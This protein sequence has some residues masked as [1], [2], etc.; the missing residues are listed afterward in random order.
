MR[1]SSSGMGFW[2]WAPEVRE[3]KTLKVSVFSQDD[4]CEDEIFF[5]KLQNSKFGIWTAVTEK[6]LTPDT[7]YRYEV[8]QNGQQLDHGLL[9]ADLIF[10]TFPT[11]ST[12]VQV[13][14]A[15]LSC[16][17]IEEY[18]KHHEE[19]K[20]KAWDMWIKLLEVSQG[21]PHLYF[22][23]L[24]GDQVYMDETFETERDFRHKSENEVREKIL[25]VYLKYWGHLS[26][27]KVMARLPSFLMWDDHD[28]ID[29]FGSRP[30]QFKRDKE[31]KHTWTIFRQYL[32]EAFYEFQAIRN[33]DGNSNRLGPFSF[34]QKIINKGFIIL[35]LRSERNATKGQ[36]L[37]ENHKKKVEAEINK[38]LGDKV[39]TIFIVSPVTVARMGSETE[40]RIGRI[41]N[42]LG[43]RLYFGI[44]LGILK[45]FV[46]G[47]LSVLFL[48]FAQMKFDKLAGHSAALGLIAFCIVNLI[49]DIK[50]K[51]NYL[52]DRSTNH[53]RNLNL[54]VIVS[55]LAWIV[56]TW[57]WNFV[58]SAEFFPRIIDSF[59][60]TAIYEARVIIPLFIS[61][62]LLS[63]AHR[64]K[65]KIKILSKITYGF[66]L[67]TFIFVVWLGLPGRN[68]NLSEFIALIPVFVVQVL[69]L[70]FYAIG[71]AEAA[72]AIDSIGGLDDDVKDSW[73]S[74]TNK[75][76]LNWLNSQIK[77]IQS[78]GVRVVVLA[79]DIHTGG[80]SKLSFDKTFS[81]RENVIYQI[82]SS[83]ISHVPMENM[84]EKLTSGNSINSIVA[85]PAGLFAF[86]L[87]YR[88]ERNFVVISSNQSQQFET[89]F[90]FEDVACPEKFHCL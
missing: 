51:I 59:I 25:G 67:I 32:T 28:L 6:K 86:N 2:L 36:L 11:E 47:V 16:N 53:L 50:T 21:N 22:L 10:K 19:E 31:E 27:R 13:D 8:T 44:N 24:A 7:N 40:G 69:G 77:K 66:I 29:G 58:L 90:Y 65:L 48:I 45:P 57:N 88:C 82:V 73:S 81:T 3:E 72:G 33:P 1:P 75:S 18:E 60:D 23:I 20:H 79:G 83:P 62:F 84:V 9:P 85:K 14:F 46:W 17:G 35:D 42:Y 30:E 39:D 74:E 89:S 55:I 78:M 4:R 52:S 70:V 80:I 43:S 15:L 26:Y 12:E 61:L 71:L 34:S 76:E 87:F 37:L 64:L 56:P 5:K 38:L 54:A 63:F 49:I 41:A 68:S